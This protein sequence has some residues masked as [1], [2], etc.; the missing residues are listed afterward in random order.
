MRIVLPKQFL[1]KRYNTK[2]NEMNRFST[3]FSIIFLMI[4]QDHLIFDTRFD[5]IIILSFV[6]IKM[7]EKIIFFTE[8]K[9]SASVLRIEIVNRSTMSFNLNLEILL[10]TKGRISS[11]CKI[12]YW[13]KPNMSFKKFPKIGVNSIES[14]FFLSRSSLLEWMAIIPF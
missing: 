3:K 4:A 8:A 12:H 11:I 6:F 14:N 13:W 7:E 10:L 9:T 5:F 1:K 2:L